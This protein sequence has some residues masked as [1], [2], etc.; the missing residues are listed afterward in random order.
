M[1]ASSRN[2]HNTDLRWKNRMEKNYKRTTKKS[3]CVCINKQKGKVCH[4]RVA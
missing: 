4:S 3:V 1:A 2:R